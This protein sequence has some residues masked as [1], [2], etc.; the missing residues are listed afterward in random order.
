MAFATPCVLTA[1][2]GHEGSEGEYRYS[3]T[4]CLTSA[5]Y[6]GGWSTPRPGRFTPYKYP[7]HIVEEAGWAPGPVWTGAENLAPTGIRYPDRPA[8]SELLY[9]LSYPGPFLRPVQ[10]LRWEITSLRIL[11]KNCNMTLFIRR[12]TLNQKVLITIPN[13]CSESRRDK[14][15]GPLSFWAHYARWEC[16]DE[17]HKIQ[18]NVGVW[19]SSFVQFKKVGSTSITKESL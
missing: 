16:S 10:K 3:S 15:H 2:K 14:R 6:G 8:R 17:S 19:W 5:L 13:I 1:C 7:V 18:S 9:R 12:F 11:M 4:L